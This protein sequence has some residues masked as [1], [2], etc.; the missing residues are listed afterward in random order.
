MVEDSE[1]G[2]I[3]YLG[4]PTTHNRLNFSFSKKTFVA[5]Q[6]KMFKIVKQKE[7]IT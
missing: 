1:L 4:K 2:L 6:G 5:F 7:K 3:R